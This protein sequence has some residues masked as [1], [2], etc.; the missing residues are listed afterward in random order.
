MTRNLSW[1]L[2]AAMQNGNFHKSPKFQRIFQ[3]LNKKKSVTRAKNHGY[4]FSG[5]PE[6]IGNPN[7]EVLEVCFTKKIAMPIFFH[8][9]H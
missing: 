6:D 4:D 8:F 1:K 5:N 7:K 2:G 3:T 9:R